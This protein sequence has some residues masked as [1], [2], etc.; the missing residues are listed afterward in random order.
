MSKQVSPV[1]HIAHTSPK[2]LC[3]QFNTKIE[4][5]GQETNPTRNLQ[6]KSRLLD[7]GKRSLVHIIIVFLCVK[8]LNIKALA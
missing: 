1:L 6:T 2:A 4:Y 7:L 8:G 5:R 3:G